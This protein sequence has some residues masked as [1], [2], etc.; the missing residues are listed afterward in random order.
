MSVGVGQDIESICTKCGDVWH[1]VV[2]KVG[3][4]IAKVQCKECGGYHR[5]RPPGGGAKK[6]PSTSAAARA[7]R[8]PKTSSRQG[9]R[10][11]E[12]MVAANLARPSRPYQF[13]E[14]YE[15]GDRIEHPKFGTGVV[16]TTSE[17]GKMQV[18]FPEGRRILARA[19]PQ[20]T[21]LQRPQR[22]PPVPDVE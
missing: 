9:A 7:R 1:V 15:P 10:I 4:K 14:A 16:E 12:P 20:G 2:A 3:D 18:F 6:A 13:A 22:P 19:K 21:G 8:E 5:Y 17:P 11:D